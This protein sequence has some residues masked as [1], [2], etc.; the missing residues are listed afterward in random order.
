MKAPLIWTIVALAVSVN[1]LCDGTP[2]DTW[3]HNGSCDYP[4]DPDCNARCKADG[5]GCGGCGGWLYGDCW[6]CSNDCDD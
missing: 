5:F 6:C 1:A 2:D 3:R 4:N